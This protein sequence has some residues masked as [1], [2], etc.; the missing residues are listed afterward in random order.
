MKYLIL[1]QYIKYYGMI[2]ITYIK[3][4]NKIALLYIKNAA[5]RKKVHQYIE[6]NYP[7]I[8]KHSTYHPNFETEED[9]CMKCDYCN[10]G[11]VKLTYHEGYAP[12]NC[13]EYYYGECSKCQHD[14]SVECRDMYCFGTFYRKR[15][16][17]ILL[18]FHSRKTGSSKKAE[19]KDINIDEIKDIIYD[20]Y[21]IDMPNINHTKKKDLVNLFT[22]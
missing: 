2:P 12:N 9:Y 21:Y 17:C 13:D 4:N 14:W 1:F 20:I 3:E 18:Y 8:N 7:D 5:N 10:K 16:N 11:F 6:T 15:H 19:K 22:F